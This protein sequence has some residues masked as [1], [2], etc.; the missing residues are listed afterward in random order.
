[1]KIEGTPEQIEALRD[2]VEA[3]IGEGF[4]TPPYTDEQYDAFEALGIRGQPC[5][6]AS[7]D[8]TRP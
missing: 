3:W 5:P 7:Y 8:V 1:M 4:T 2:I 6:T